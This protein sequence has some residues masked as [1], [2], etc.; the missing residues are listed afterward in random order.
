VRVKC[1]ERAVERGTQWL[2][3]LH[4]LRQK[5]AAVQCGED[6]EGELFGVGVLA[7]GARCTHAFDAGAQ[8]APPAVH[9]GG[10]FGAV[11]R[12]TTAF[13]HGTVIDV[14]GGRVGVAVIVSCGSYLLLELL[15]RRTRG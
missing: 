4:G 9:V 5:Q 15:G 14:D 7:Q 8:V 12:V 6:S 2:E 13:V 1:C 11:R 10:D 3:R